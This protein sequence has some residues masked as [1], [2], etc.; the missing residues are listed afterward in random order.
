MESRERDVRLEAEQRTVK[1]ESG[2]YEL[3]TERDLSRNGDLR[4]RR[5]MCY[6]TTNKSKKIK[7]E[8]FISLDM[9]TSESAVLQWSI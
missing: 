9:N 5:L 8:T 2:K 4:M 3:R 7:S 1:K 6:K